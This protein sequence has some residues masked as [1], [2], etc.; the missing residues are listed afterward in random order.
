MNLATD[1]VA[2]LM[3]KARAAANAAGAAWLAAATPRYS[4]HQETL[5]GHRGPAVG[6][7]LDLCGGAYI[8]FTDRRCSDFKSFKRA[9]AIRHESTVDLIH[10]FR[11]RQEHGLNVACM[12][13]AYKV[14]KDAGI[15]NI[16]VKDY[17]D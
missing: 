2:D 13:A 4:V 15:S 7:M 3:D 17:I 14:F 1:A 16:T 10:M 6:T 5:D 9:N 11:G 12:E 8:K